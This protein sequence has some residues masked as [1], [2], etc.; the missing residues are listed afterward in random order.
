MAGIFQLTKALL[1]FGGDPE[2]RRSQI[3]VRVELLGVE[4]VGKDLPAPEL[5][6]HL[7]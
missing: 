2:R 6:E 1:Q 3:Q 5:E 4:S 7:G